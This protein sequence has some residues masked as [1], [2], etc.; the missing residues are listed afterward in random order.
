MTPLRWAQGQGPGGHGTKYHVVIRDMP[1]SRIHR[2]G[3]Q[4]GACGVHFVQSEE[5]ADGASRD[6]LQGYACATCL[7][8]FPVPAENVTVDGQPWPKWENGG[9]PSP[10]FGG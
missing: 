5:W 3:Y 1:A 8:K 2:W 7:G 10:I 9:I 6:Y 4:V